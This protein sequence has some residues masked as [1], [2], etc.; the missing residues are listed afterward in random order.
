MPDPTTKTF[1]DLTITVTPDGKTTEELNAIAQRALSQEPLATMLKDTRH[2][3]LSVTQFDQHEE[4]KSDAAAPAPNFQAVIQDYTNRRTV[5][6]TAALASPERMV[7]EESADRPVLAVSEFE[8][9]I[10][11]VRNHDAFRG[12]ANAFTPYQAMPGIMGDQLD[13]GSFERI[14]TVG[15]LPR[16][17]SF[18]HEIVGV[19]LDTN[20]VVRFPNGAPPGSS[21]GFQ[22]CGITG[23]AN[24]QTVTSAAGQVWITVKQGSTTLWKF[25]AVRPA[26]SSGTRGSGVELRFVDFKGK[27]VLYR[28]HV[29]ILNVRY[30]ADACGPYRD[31]QNQEGMIQAVGVDV[32]PGFRLCTA[33]AQTILESGTDIGNYLGTAIYVKGQEVVLVC[34]MQAGWYRY[35]SEWRLHSNGTIHPRFGFGA[36]KNSCVCNRHH[37]HAYWR[38]DFDI[39]TASNNL[40]REFNDPPLFGASNWHDKKFEIKR[41]RDPA[42]KRKW[43]VLN[44]GSG[45]AYDIVPTPEDGEAMKSPDW[46]FGQGDVWVLRYHGNELDDGVNIVQGP[47]ASVQ[48]HLDNFVNGESVQNTDVVV[49]YAG[50]VVHDVNNDPPGVF[51]HFT[52]PLLVPAK[53]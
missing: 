44:T 36:I 23:D 2:G 37:H 33:P 22:T 40:V 31:W 32:A 25:L 53:W 6:V 30:D 17:D 3:L 7:V 41:F 45:D 42:R 38:F 50:H 46:P 29:P 35:V 39:K 12:N 51:G 13:D 15:L 26:A 47:A 9:A 4:A 27:R 11:L 19:N 14:L 48:A 28:A 1:G 16:N 10:R 20:A 49:W 43:R 8:Q 5:R 18:R 34:E 21:A 24:Q 52:G